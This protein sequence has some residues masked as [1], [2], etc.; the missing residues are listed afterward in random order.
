MPFRKS[1]SWG[2]F[3]PPL[4]AQV[5][6]GHPLA[7]NLTAFWMFNEGGGTLVKDNV[8]GKFNGTI[9]K[10]GASTNTYWSPT[11]Y[12]MGI[13][14]D[15]TSTVNGISLPTLA[16]GTTYS[17][18]AWIYPN[19]CVNGQYQNM[20][21]QLDAAGIWILGQASGNTFKMAFFSTGGNHTSTT[22]FSVN[23]WTHL[24]ITFNA[25]VMTFYLN[26]KADGSFS[27]T[28]TISY[29]GMFC[30]NGGDNVAQFRG[31]CAYQRFWLNR[32]LTLDEIRQLY[33]NPYDM[34]TPQSRRVISGADRNRPR[35]GGLS[36][37][38]IS[39]GPISGQAPGIFASAALSQPVSTIAIPGL[40]G[41]TG[42][43]ALT[44][45]VSVLLITEAEDFFATIALTQASSSIAITAAS[46]VGSLSLTQATDS[47]TLKNYNGLLPWQPIPV[48]N[49]RQRQAE[50]SLQGL[51]Q[52]K[53]LLN[54]IRQAAPTLQQTRQMLPK[55]R[56]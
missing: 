50:V 39:A 3:K 31:N 27:G 23:A 41:V 32:V 44:Q 42:T 22:A 53:P 9:A 47:I 4:G 46:F 24:A 54:E 17:W 14:H 10:L 8:A 55:L 16:S 12:G 56:D 30:D 18:E 52:A 1:K 20:I 28:T 6:L 26:G 19:V 29:N 49:T 11:S 38:P 15:T 7:R 51:R 45:G 48:D 21:T 13:G 25:G 40:I 5:N 33:F 34:V 35:Q 43:I 36:S 2:N 37:A